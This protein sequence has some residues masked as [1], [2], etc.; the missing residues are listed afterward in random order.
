MENTFILNNFNNSTMLNNKILSKINASSIETH[1]LKSLENFYINHENYSILLQIINTDTFISIRLIDYFITKFSKHNKINLKINNIENVLNIYIS[2]KQQ[3]KIYQKK[4]FDPF[5][6]GDRIP[7]F[8][9]NICIIT[10]IGQLNFFKWFLSKNIYNYMLYNKAVIENDMNI[11]NKINK[12][13]IKKETKKNNKIKLNKI[14][15]NNFI[16]NNNEN[17]N[18]NKNIIVTF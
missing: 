6:R 2:Y 4:Y 10:T 18:I 5:S 1:I 8:L 14:I 13:K 3:L 17:I 7:Y 9:G 11:F 12:N 16:K 15:N